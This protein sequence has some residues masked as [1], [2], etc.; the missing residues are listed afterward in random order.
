MIKDIIFLILGAIFGW[1]TTHL[2][3]K[4]ANRDN[5]IEIERLKKYI[6]EAIGESEKTIIENSLQYE[7]IDE[8][9]D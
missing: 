8:W 1:L 9:K 4:K 2:Y 5:K 6:K 7:V 3:Y